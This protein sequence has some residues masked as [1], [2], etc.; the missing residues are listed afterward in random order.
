MSRIPLSELRSRFQTCGEINPSDLVELASD[1]RRGVRQFAQ[2]LRR[3]LQKTAEE[4]E[5]LL[6]MERGLRE[7]GFV[8]IAGIDEAG[9]GPLA[10]PVVAA[11]VVFPTQM[12]VSGVKDS[13][14]ISAR[15][16]ER[17]YDVILKEALS[18]GIG[19]VDEKEIDR[20]NIL[21]ATH[22][23]MSKAIEKLSIRP[24]CVLVDG[25]ELPEC[26]CHQKAV[27]DGDAR[28]FSIAAASIIAKVTRD[29]IMID[30]DRQFPQYG[31]AQH[32]GYATAGH[33]AALEKFGPSNI[34]RTSF[35]WKRD[36]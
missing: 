27:I 34:H 12:Y 25:M 21:K 18:V 2:R 3:R 5:R 23:A 1:P 33:R 6:A 7:K 4:K 9:R 36:V 31:F 30:Y 28:C 35:S 29:R 19:V 14:R 15:R 11:A 26:S 20:I 16:R 22:K 10:G 32:K 24:H 13:K 17:L 8:H